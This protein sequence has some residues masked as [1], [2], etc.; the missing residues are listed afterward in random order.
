[1]IALVFASAR[2]AGE[3]ERY[4]R[5]GCQ[6][7]H[8]ATSSHSARWGSP[9]RQ[10]IGRPAGNLCWRRLRPADVRKSPPPTSP[11]ANSDAQTADCLRKSSDAMKDA[12]APTHCVTSVQSC[13]WEWGGVVVEERSGEQIWNRATFCDPFPCLQ[14]KARDPLIPRTVRNFCRGPT[15][16]SIGQYLRDWRRS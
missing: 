16:L 8:L 9:S 7:Y 2:A 13:I 12:G 3:E 15:F 4:P 5:V 1:V 10:Q 6:F 11:L 14:S